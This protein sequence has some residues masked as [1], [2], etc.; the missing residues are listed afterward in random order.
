MKA[1]VWLLRVLGLLP[2]LVY[3]VEWWGVAVPYV[4][5]TRPWLAI[6]AAVLLLW[7]CSRLERFAV[8]RSRVRAL[9]M[10][11]LTGLAAIAC[12]FS[13]IGIELGHKLD[14]L[15]VIVAVDRSRS[16]DLVPGAASRLEREL[17]VAEQ[18]M[19]EGDRIGTLAF[20]AEAVVEDP[21]RERRHPPAPQRAELSRDGTD[22][23][24]AIRRALSEV[25]PDSAARVVLL[26]DGVSTHGDALGEAAL[27][28][29][30]GVRIDVIPLDQRKLNDIRVV[31]VSA[32]GRASQGEAIDLRIVTSS[33]HDADVQVR[34][35]RDG[36]LIREGDAS[37]A[38]GEDVVHL[39]EVADAPGLH[40][41]DVELSAKDP[42]LDE[43]VEDNRG[44]SFVRV[45]GEA[46]ALVLE[47]DKPLA[48]PM[49]RA[50]S[51]A[52]FK[53]HAGD[54]TQ[55]PA[56]A[57]G[58]ALY[59]L[60]VLSDISAVDLAPEQMEA[61]ASYVRDLGGGLLLMGGDRSLGPGGYG[62]T[63]IEEISP[64][65]FDVKQ[66][67]RRASLAE[68]IAVD[69]SG[70]MGA[71]VGSRTKLDLANEAAVRSMEL[72]GA[73][74]RLGV[75]HVDTAVQWTIPLGE[76]KDREAMA[77][78]V[79]AVGVGGGGIY[80]DLS[81][82]TA[83]AALAK[84]T[85]QLKHLLLFAD[86]SDA[87]ERSRAFSLV[88]GAKARG[89]T[90]SV[91]ALGKGSDVADLER[92]SKLGDGRFYL[93]E[94]AT[95]LPAV[96]AQ[97]TVLAARSSINEVPF[98]PSLV[99]NSP[100]L[101]GV[102]L[103]Q[104]PNLTGYVVTLPKGRAQVSLAGPEGDPLLASWS[105]GVGRAAVFTS[106]FKDRWGQAWTSWNGAERLFAQLGRDLARHAESPRVRL[107]ADTSGG[108]LRLRA[109]V[110]DERGRSESLRRLVAKVTAPDGTSSSIPLS[111][112]GPGL[113]SAA[114]PAPRPGAYVASLVDEQT[115]AP[116]ATTGA[117]LAL[118]D[119]LRPT[120]TDRGLLRRIARQSGGKERDTLAGIFLDRDAERFAYTPLSALLIQLAAFGLL[121]AVAA[122]RLS[123][124]EW[125]ERFWADLRAPHRQPDAPA[126]PEVAQSSALGALQ[127]VRSRHAAA[128]ADEE[129][130]PSV[131]R[132]SRPPPPPPARP[133][134]PE[135]KPSGRRA[136]PPPAEA[137]GATTGRAPTAAEILLARRRGR[138]G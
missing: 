110:T 51:G 5:L 37:I 49:V 29:A 77:K 43:A 91:V 88:S 138:K 121:L 75:M 35:Y 42:T 44:S 34:V 130:P 1:L 59:D 68:V 123:T 106:D 46:S 7:L 131:P 24:A 97:E 55:V 67:R 33:A 56:D 137:P 95:R 93:I 79:R 47:R 108:E 133:P 104:A 58:F 63:P 73:G 65:S 32:G 81:L 50:L 61:L 6:P 8:R 122:R 114:V 128:P 16:I 12:A 132:F 22:L 127:R 54:A 116:E 27:A 84:E 115:Q 94:D 15:A 23:G 2:A 89:I 90:T 69:Y 66:E 39:R 14:R 113:Y 112:V 120:G 25:P 98:R 109:S 40:R 102:D 126:Q 103:A 26:S 19:R 57:A 83:Y 74:D 92:M 31:S 30:A 72:L 20:A 129:P 136:S 99:T 52:G 9:S 21:L 134:V 100:V 78:T 28:A 71:S 117:V 135:A 124:P 118:G 38:A 76:I 62:K 45:T 80:V 36:E 85:V 13:V 41:Y 119:E 53:V 64:V 96:F 111:A 86:G 18:G 125:L 105:V 82:Q 11:A 17:Q 107:E 87:E 3:A 48:A 4:R 10:T 60:V 101:R 70:S